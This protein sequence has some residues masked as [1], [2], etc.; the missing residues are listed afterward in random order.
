MRVAKDRIV[1]I[2]YAIRLPGGEVV[3][4]T[5][6]SGPLQYLHGRAQIVPGVERA[7]EGAFVGEER[8]VAVTP[9]DGYG[10][11]DPEGVFLVP[12]AAFPSD[13]AVEAGMT[14]SATRPDGQPVVFSIVRVEEQLVLVDTNHPLAGQHLHVWVA[15][16]GVRE[17][18]AAELTDD[19]AE[20]EEPGVF[21]DG[22]AE[23]PLLS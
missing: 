3:E 19:E 10:E 18:T 23:R 12:R 21:S 5:T 9:E 13:E 1:S 8:D 7:I 20:E 17:A 6:D 14:F 4:S 2:D 11:R 15:V 16:R 22:D